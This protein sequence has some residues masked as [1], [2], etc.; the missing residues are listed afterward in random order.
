MRN[1]PNN[2]IYSMLIINTYLRMYENCNII[3][4]ALLVTIDYRLLYLFI[5]KFYTY[6]A[7]Q[8]MKYIGLMLK[9]NSAA[10]KYPMPSSFNYFPGIGIR[11]IQ[12]YVLQ[13]D[14]IHFIYIIVSTHH[15]I[16]YLQYIIDKAS[17]LAFIFQ[18][19]KVLYSL[20][21]SMWNVDAISEL[22]V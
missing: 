8:W 15:I 21:H 2:A 18:N 11:W 17:L 3:Q 13:I 12:R 10:N 20:N 1:L 4:A 6:F 22:Q 5:L 14:Q 19:Y 7:I 9:I 16:D